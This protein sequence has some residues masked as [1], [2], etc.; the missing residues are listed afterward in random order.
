MGRWAGDMLPLP[1]WAGTVSPGTF[2]TVDL[3]LYSFQPR[4]GSDLRVHIPACL[5]GVSKP[6]LQRR[7]KWDP[8]VIFQTPPA[9]V[10]CREEPLGTFLTLFLS[11][12]I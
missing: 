8:M 4:C 2:P 11:Y 3:F 5:R 12:L 9:S 1:T 7:W 10:G 6:T